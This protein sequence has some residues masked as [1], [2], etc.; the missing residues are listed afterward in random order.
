MKVS[1][2]IV[3]VSGCAALVLLQLIFAL[4]WI[5]GAPALASGL[6][7]EFSEYANDRGLIQFQISAPLVILQLILI[8]IIYLLWLVHRNR[9]FSPRVDK[10][11]KLLVMTTLALSASFIAIGIWLSI[12]QTLPPIV[13][14]GL[15]GC[16]LGSFSV[17]MVTQSLL[18]LLRK[19]THVSQE[20]EGVI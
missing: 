16:A 9:M 11:V 7:N 6:Q 17:A 3:F 1:E 12:K 2:R 8:E 18:G 5:Y 20:L 15:M 4:G 13:L 19:A 10:W 14:F